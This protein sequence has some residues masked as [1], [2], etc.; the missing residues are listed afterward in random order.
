[1]MNMLRSLLILLCGSVILSIVNRLLESKERR[2]IFECNC[3][4]ES[5][6]YTEVRC[7]LRTVETFRCHYAEVLSWPDQ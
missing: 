1:M 4:D 5:Y 7:D 6:A 2:R 3:S